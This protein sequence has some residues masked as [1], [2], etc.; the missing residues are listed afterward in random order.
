MKGY[1]TT[2]MWRII[3]LS[4][5]GMSALFFL[6]LG[7][8][9]MF[10]YGIL[11]AYRPGLVFQWETWL[12]P[13]MFILVSTILM[14]IAIAQARA[15]AHDFI[16]MVRE[17][18]H[19]LMD[20]A[21]D[22]KDD[23]IDSSEFG[24]NSV[25]VEI[26]GTIKD[27]GGYVPYLMKLF[28]DAPYTREDVIRSIAKLSILSLIRVPEHGGQIITVTPKGLD[29]LK[30]PPSTFASILPWDLTRMLI[31]ARALYQEGRMEEAII[32]T[33]NLLERALKVHLI[34]SVD[35]Y[36]R[37][38]NEK[39]RS[40]VGDDD[41]AF[42]LYSWKGEK[43]IAGLNDLWNFYKRE[44]NL[45]RKWSNFSD[46]VVKLTEKE[47]AV[48]EEHLRVANSAVDVISDTRS[49]YAHNKPGKKSK[50]DAYRLITL[51]E[52]LLGLWF[53]M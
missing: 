35:D 44:A 23:D 41:K 51:T 37:K 48:A 31:R 28:N 4:P 40:K 14:Y 53:E 45:G 24:I 16:A 2:R 8:S 13:L 3:F 26:L 17:E 15:K 42:H 1:N 11:L 52:V 10:I 18:E 32:A 46:R 36:E 47:K 49:R 12:Y 9:G 7:V 19:R 22:E 21:S 34:P 33:Y 50:K 30:M 6:V 27:S 38:W 39:V 20:L 5:L 29:T 25:D 43:T